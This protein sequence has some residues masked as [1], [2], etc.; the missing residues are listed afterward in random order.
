MTPT[1]LSAL[2]LATALLVPLSPAS[3]DPVPVLSVDATFDEDLP[4][5]V[6]PAGS[7]TAPISVVVTT[8]EP[9]AD[10]EVSAYAE[11][12]GLVIEDPDRSLGTVAGTQTVTFQVAGAAPGVHELVVDVDA[13]D[14]SASTSLYYVWTT[15]SPVSGPKGGLEPMSFGW[16]STSGPRA[17]RMVS[18]LD[19][20]WAYL[21][22]PAR[23]A[24]SCSGEGG[25]CVRYS[26]D[27]D[28]D[29]LQLGSSVI[30][31]LYGEKRP[32]ALYTEGLAPVPTRTTSPSHFAGP[33][34][35]V[36]GTWSWSGSGSGLTMQKVTFK[37]SG[38]YKLEYAYDGGKATRLKGTYTLGPSGEVT[39][40]AKAKKGTKGKGP[41]SVHAKPGKPGKPKKAK[42]VQRG[43]VLVVEQPADEH[44]PAAPAI[45]L[46]LSGKKGTSPDGNLLTK[47]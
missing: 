19:G 44:G 36:V 39:F 45:W 23:G 7:G 12:D 47:R 27:E 31:A 25:G 18:I 38:K 28:E 14:A 8:A 41:K 5:A 34:D 37:A 24:P 22:L 4:R 11:D 33:K 32:P 26:Y 21:G 43:T 30:G 40:S 16:Q 6:P 46:V 9:L 1:R 15:G 20:G 42:V 17:V 10:V 2:A 3:A 35:S 13:G 29:V